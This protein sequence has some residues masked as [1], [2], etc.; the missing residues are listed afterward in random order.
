MY[1]KYISDPKALT[2]ILINNKI[3]FRFIKWLNDPFEC[4][5]IFESGIGSDIET[6]TECF[7]YVYFKDIGK[8]GI[9]DVYNYGFSVLSLSKTKDNL[10]MWA[11]YANAH[12]GVVIEFDETNEFFRGNDIINEAKEVTY[13]KNVPMLDIY[14][15]KFKDFLYYKSEDWKYENEVRL[16]KFCLNNTTNSE[17]I[18]WMKQNAENSYDVKDVQGSQLVDIPPGLIT[19]VY[20]GAN[21]DFEKYKDILEKIRN[22]V[23][24]YRMVFKKDSFEVIQDKFH[25]D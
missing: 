11:H 2:S 4:Q 19:G 3:M 23:P 24:V 13:L 1:Y 18:E 8:N 9:Q 21:F 17:P 7:A 12:K 10:L 5:F 25:F 16:T 22:K 15:Y 20:L 6:L 14:N